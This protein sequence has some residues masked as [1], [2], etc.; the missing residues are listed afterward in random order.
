MQIGLGIAGDRYGKIRLIATLCFCSVVACLLAAAAQSLGQLTIARLLCGAATSAM[1]PVSLAWVGDMLPY[2]ERPVVLARY[3]GGGIFGMVAG[4]ILGGLM[5]E[6]WDWRAGLVMVAFVYLI[7]GIGLV[8]Q[9]RRDPLI[10]ARPLE[11]Q[12]RLS[13]FAA[14]T[15]MLRRPWSRIVLASVFIEGVSIFASVTFVGVELRERFSASYGLIGLMLAFFAIGGFA[16]TSSVRRIVPRFSQPRLIFMGATIS[17][18]GLLAFAFAPVIW[19]VPPAITLVGFGAYMLHNT[20]QTF[21][22]Q[23]LPEARATGFSFFA[24]L[25]F[26]SQSAGVALSAAFITRFGAKPIFIA[27]AF[28]ALIF[29]IWFVLRASRAMPAPQQP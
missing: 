2:Q 27:A 12:A 5:T 10:A 23:L 25:Y 28:V 7:A 13:T 20:L 11:V 8:V 29:G 14:V 17:A 3:A 18:G 6:Y 15:G 16:Y 1:V 22:T 9:L 21:A 19:L 26:L 24:T 4:Q